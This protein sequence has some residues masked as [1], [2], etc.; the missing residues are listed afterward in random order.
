MKRQFFR[1]TLFCA[2][3]II[4]LTVVVSADNVAYPV[5]GGNLY[6]DT[7]TGAI[8]SCDKS[9][10]KATIP[11]KINGVNVTTIEG[12]RWVGAIWDGG[13]RRVKGGAFEDCSQLTSVVIP[14]SVTTIECWAFSGCNNLTSI[15]IPEGVGI[16][17]D[18]AFHGCRNLESII[19]PNSVIYIGSAAFCNCIS[20]TSIIIPANAETIGFDTSDDIAITGAGGNLGLGWVF[21]GCENLKSIT[22]P[23]SVNYIGESVFDGCNSLTDVYYSGTEGQWRT[24]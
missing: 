8:T 5:E 22:I 16:I 17:G 20:L 19:L 4:F 1:G 18:D 12:A 9:V 14:Q 23:Q 13:G 7:T 24:I 6:F 11:S 10:T 3:F 21:Y 2:L 15:T